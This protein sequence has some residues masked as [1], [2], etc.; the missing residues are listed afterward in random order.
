MSDFEHAVMKDLKIGKY[1]MVD[2]VPCKVVEIEVSAPGKHGAAKMRV[3]AIALFEGTKKT[4]LK[5]SDAGIQVP[6][7]DRKRGQI[8]TLSGDN[9]GV[10]DLAT[11]ENFEMQIP[12]EFKAAAEAG[13]E[14]EYIE[15]MGR[16]IIMRIA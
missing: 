16:K 1:V 5:P 8:V 3:T 7:I 9:A 10:M 4:L 11:Y 15:T 13:K 2:G 12:E 14:I 6:I